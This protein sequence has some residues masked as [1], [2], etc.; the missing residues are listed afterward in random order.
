MQEI[1]P[2]IDHKLILEE[3]TEDKF[4]RHTSKDGNL[5]YLITHHDSPNVMREIGRLRELS[6]RAAGGGTGKE[7]DIDEYD[8][9]EFPY[10]QLIVWN[11]DACEII[12]G[13]RLMKCTDAAKDAHGEI[14]TATAHLFNLSDI[15]HKEYLPYT[16]ELGR[17]FVQ[18]KYQS[19]GTSTKGIYSLDNLWDGLGAIV[20]KNP[21]IRYLF[22]KVTMYPD[23]NREARNMLLSFMHSYFP[24]NIGL[25]TPIE[26]LI[27]KEELAPYDHMWEGLSYKEGHTLL[28]KNIRERG[29][30]IPPLINS[31]MNLSASMKTFGTAANYEFG[32]VEETGILVTIDDI[33][34]AKK[35]RYIRTYE[36]HKDFNNPPAK[37]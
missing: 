4:L 27:T 35:E 34:E 18:P 1:I 29:E 26:P 9:S 11:P 8:T 21:D 24:D 37:Q 23:Y 3:L 16:L 22:G 17:S 12:A 31:Y 15:F 30:N 13:Y 10:Q 20:A 33:Y 7:I 14:L 19:R 28:N 25:G 32:K 2:A 36:A 5:L 6:F